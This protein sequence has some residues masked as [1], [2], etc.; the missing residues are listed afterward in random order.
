[1]V[2]RGVRKRQRASVADLKGEARVVVVTL[3][4]LDIG[5]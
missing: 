5:G 2:E 4:V 3:P 1:V